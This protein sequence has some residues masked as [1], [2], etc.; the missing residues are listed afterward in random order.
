MG[1]VC[2]HCSCNVRPKGLVTKEETSL[3]LNP[4]SAALKVPTPDA[5]R[6]MH[7]Y[8]MCACP[9]KSWKQTGVRWAQIGCSRLC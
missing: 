2:P 5:V 3:L 9:C 7:R 4:T 1:R 6:D 8:V